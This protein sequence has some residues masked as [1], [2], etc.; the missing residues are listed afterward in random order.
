MTMSDE[1]EAGWAR[2]VQTYLAD[3]Y[4]NYIAWDFSFVGP[5]AVVAGELQAYDLIEPFTQG[6]WRLTL[7][8]LLAILEVHG[9][10]AEA[11]EKLDA[12]GLEW[13][14][15]ELPPEC[16]FGIGTEQALFNELEA[17]GFVEPLTQG[18]MQLTEY[19]KQW[20]LSRR[21]DTV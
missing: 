11:E 19:G 14:S 2:L 15:K 5:E 9:M 3:G 10:S 4:Q 12:M 8:G 7:T 18:T 16:L 17:R 13:R 20:L 21:S 6:T 1:A